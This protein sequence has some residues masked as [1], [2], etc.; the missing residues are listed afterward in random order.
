MSLE[1]ALYTRKDCH[2][3][4]EMKETIRQVAKQIPF[5]LKEID[6]SESAGLEKEFGQ[7]IP[8]LLINGRKAFKYRATAREL[9]AKLKRERRSS[10]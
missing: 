1:L 9:A 3:C 8:V 7:E 4:E 10:P 2:L 5:E 6:V